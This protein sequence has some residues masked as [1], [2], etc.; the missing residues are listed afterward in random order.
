MA[1][2]PNTPPQRTPAP[3]RTVSTTASTST[4]NLRVDIDAWGDD[5]IESLR[6]TH[7][8]PPSHS[9]LGS[10]AVRTSTGCPLASA[11]QRPVRGT[12]IALDIPLDTEAP[13][14]AEQR[15]SVATAEYPEGDRVDSVQQPGPQPSGYVRRRPS[16][17][18]SLRR[19]EALLKGKEGSRRRQKWE[20]GALSSFDPPSLGFTSSA[21]CC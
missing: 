6:R 18:D 15:R 13:K 21:V 17:R 20:N 3:P 1:T 4:G 10:T 2:G 16:D 19:R 8:S 11:V 14:R 7:I 12:S 5:A 9:A